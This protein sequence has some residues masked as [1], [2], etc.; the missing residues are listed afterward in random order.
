MK[1]K[2]GTSLDSALYRRVQEAARRQGRSTN[3]VI[4]DALTRFLSSRVAPAS[5]VEETKGTYK[6]SAK[7]VR[8]VL[9]EQLYGAE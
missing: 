3:A 8:A 2:V 6:A 1:R 5:V 9:R 7:A 4:E